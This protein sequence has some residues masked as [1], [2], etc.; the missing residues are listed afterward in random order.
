MV[1]P[2]LGEG[3][4]KVIGLKE[5]MKRFMPLTRLVPGSWSC[6]DSP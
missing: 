5:P 2:D 4:G 1:Q 3:K 6:D